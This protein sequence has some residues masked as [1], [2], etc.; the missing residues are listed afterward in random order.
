MTEIEQELKEINSKIIKLQKR[1]TELLEQKENLKQKAY[2]KQ[3]VSISDQ[4]KWTHTGIQLCFSHNNNKFFFLIINFVNHFTDFAW[5]ENVQNTL[6]NVFQLGS[7]RSQQLAAINITLSK[8]DA[9]LIMPTGGGK[10][11]CY[12]L[13]AL[14]DKGRYPVFIS[15]IICKIYLVYLKIVAFLIIYLTV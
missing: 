9:I 1:K 6:K 15:Y 7:F 4:S 3:T 14:I 2:Q 10:S 13:P 11:L 8:H 5:H 12:Q